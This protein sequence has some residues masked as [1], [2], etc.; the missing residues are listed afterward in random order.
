M[1]LKCLDSARSAGISSAHSPK[2]GKCEISSEAEKP[3]RLCGADFVRFTYVCNDG[4]VRSKVRYIAE[5]ITSSLPQHVGLSAVEQLMTS[6]D[7]S[8]IANPPINSSSELL[9]KADW[10]SF[11]LIPHCER[12]GRVFGTIVLGNNDAWELCPRTF[13]INATARACDAGYSFRVAFEN[14]FYIFDGNSSFSPVDRSVYCQD[15]AFSGMADFMSDMVQS[16]EAASVVPVT[17]HPESGPGQFEV[18]ITPS[19]PI[20]SADDQVIVRSTIKDMAAQRQFQATF[21][22]RPL[23]DCPSSGSHINLSVWKD[24]QNI[25]GEGENLSMI[26]GAFVAGIL[27]H[28]PGLVAI[29]CPNPNS[30]S[31]LQPGMWSG[32]LRGWG[33]SNREA[34]VRVPLSKGG[35]IT[36]IEYRCADATCNPYL[37][38]GAILFAGMDGIEKMQSLPLETKKNSRKPSSRAVVPQNLLQ[39]L[40]CLSRDSVLRDRM[41]RNLHACFLATRRAESA[42]IEA[43]QPNDVIQLLANRF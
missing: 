25:T 6:V 42:K 18:A 29:T 19:D 20:K 16:L 2:N 41:G 22:P 43:M 1:R 4:V 24:G 15:D 3:S 28:L 12:H 38:L 10:D 26:G 9:L 35:K 31:R 17:L 33:R 13:L 32:T 40:R 30:Y 23:P 14:E 11:R 5:D 7:D 27:S 8:V 34:A 39:S 36:H 37:A 21:L